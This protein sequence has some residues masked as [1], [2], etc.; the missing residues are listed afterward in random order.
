MA[1]VH[2]AHEC[3]IQMGGRYQRQDG[4]LATQ[5]TKTIRIV[6]YC[7]SRCSSIIFWRS[8]HNQYPYASAE[9]IAVLI[10]DRNFASGR[11]GVLQ[12]RLSLFSSVFLQRS[13]GGSWSSRLPIGRCND[14]ENAICR[15][16]E[17]WRWLPLRLFS[18]RACSAARFGWTR[19]TQ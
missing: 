8:A 3:P 14:R 10:L 18:V 1:W 15:L 17:H 16:S 12:V 4:I 19:P 6:N 5:S 7:K 11:H 9:R 13:S 2:D